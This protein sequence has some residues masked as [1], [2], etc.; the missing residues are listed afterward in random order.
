WSLQSVM[1]QTLNHPS[2]VK[3][4]EVLNSK[5][6][7]KVT[8][9]LSKVRDFAKTKG[10]DIEQNEE[11]FNIYSAKEKQ[12]KKP[13]QNFSVEDISSIKEMLSQLTM[14]SH[15]AHKQLDAQ[16]AYIKR[17]VLTQVISPLIEEFKKD[18]H[19]FLGDWIDEFQEDVL[20]NADL[21]TSFDE[22]DEVVRSSL[23]KQHYAVNVFVDNSK[24]SH[25]EVILEPSITYEA[26]FGSIKYR[27]TEAGGYETHFTLIRPGTL[28]KA[29]GGILI[30]RAEALAKDPTLWDEL[31]SALRDKKIRI[32]ERHREN[33]LPTMD[34]P[35]PMSIPL[36]VQVIL[37]AS[38]IWYYNFFFLDPE[39]RTYFKIK[40]EID[41]IMDVTPHNLLAYAALIEK[42]SKSSSSIPISK[43]GISRL[44]GQSSRW[45]NHRN[46]LSAR[47][48]II[49]DVIAEASSF[50][51]TSNKDIITQ[52]D[53]TK[54]L[55]ERRQRN[56][57]HEDEALEEILN[58]QLLVQTTGNAIGQVNGLSVIN[59]GDH[60]F[61]LPCRITAQTFI[62]EEGIINIDHLSDMSGPLQQKS[63]FILDGLLKGL[64]GQTFKPSC[65]CSVAFEQNYS[66]IE[67][68]SASIAEIVAIISSLSE[69]PVRQD[70][71]V[72][73][74]LNQFGVVQAVGGIYQK[75][76]GFFNLCQKRGL[77]QTQGVIIPSANKEHLT[78][79]EKVTMAVEDGSFKIYTID[80]LEDALE[81][82]L[83]HPV[84]KKLK[85]G[86]YTKDSI[87]DRVYKKLKKFHERLA[88]RGE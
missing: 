50:A 73:G 81:L 67:G 53:I 42:A 66:G 82:L 27:A 29:N 79:L 41:T 25:P 31:K 51:L 69:L 64:F 80:H 83:G 56:A 61:G 34:A 26:L 1:I 71:G 7:D 62:G 17:D 5:L 16:I 49:S 63:T 54:A 55:Q 76:E 38:P 77:T 13:P 57:S 78:L 33:S 19:N 36:D 10:L 11:G 21:F 20:S 40:A 72:T 47:F 9:E 4:V 30:L 14:A 58:N 86:L 12:R 43:D 59:T 8:Q 68:D 70:L 44:I 15:I 24:L 18:F 45:A 22:E 60:Q 2:Y 52:D 74:S 39:F 46:K 75:V 6:Q 3:Q 85:N 65:S 32:R 37:V 88:H 28:H 84:G 35:E 48:E 23:L 87:Y